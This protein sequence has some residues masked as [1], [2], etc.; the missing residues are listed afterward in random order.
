[1]AASSRRAVLTGIGVLNP[2]GLDPASYWE[3][4]ASGRSGIRPIQSFDAS[5]LPV[6][7]LDRTVQYIASSPREAVRLRDRLVAPAT[8]KRRSQRLKPAESERVERLARVMAL[9]EEVWESREDARQF[10]TTPH[11]LLDGARPLDLARSE[12]GARRV[13]ELLWRLEYSLPA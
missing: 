2:L 9:A 7:T 13:E 8:R 11:A 12:L 5:G 10:L 1:M 6:R 4:L 3:G